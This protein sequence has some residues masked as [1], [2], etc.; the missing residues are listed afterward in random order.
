MRDGSLL[1]LVIP[2]PRLPQRDARVSAI[3]AGA[4]HM[5]AAALVATH[6]AHGVQMVATRSIE[7]AAGDE[8]VIELGDTDAPEMLA[9]A[10]LNGLAEIS[11]GLGVARSRAITEAAMDAIDSMHGEPQHDICRIAGLKKT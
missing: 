4:L 1:Q 9:L 10:G 6:E 7:R 3:A 2:A 8:S 5:A 11:P